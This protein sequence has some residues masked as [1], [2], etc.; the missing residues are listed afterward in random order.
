LRFDVRR[1]GLMVLLTDIPLLIALYYLS[2]LVVLLVRMLAT[3]LSPSLYRQGLTRMSFN[4]AGIAAGT[5]VANMIVHGNQLGNDVNPRTWLVLGVAVLANQLPMAI[6]V[7]GVMLLMQ[8]WTAI[9]QVLNSYWPVL[10][11]TSINIIFGLVMLSALQTSAYS[12][13]LLVA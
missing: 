11:V 9:D 6:A 12:V 13:L 8:G 10:A 1:S 2:P 5:A 7:G 3:V 4:V